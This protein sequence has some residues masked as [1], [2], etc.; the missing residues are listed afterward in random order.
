[1]KL[2]KKAREKMLKRGSKHIFSTGVEDSATELCK[3]NMKYGLAK[4]HYLQEQFGM[5]PDATFISTPD[6]TVTRNAAR[7]NQGIAYGGKLSWGDGKDKLVVLDTKPNT[8]GMLV[9]GLNSIPSPEKLLRK[10]QELNKE[11]TY[12]KN[13]KVKWDFNK[14]NHFI[15]VFKVE[16]ASIKLPHYMVIIHAGSPEMKSENEA[17]MGLYF[18]KSNYLQKVY[19]NIKTPFG[20][21]YILTE[22]DAEDYYKFYQF[23]EEFSKKRREIAFKELFGGKVVC[24][25]AHQGLINMNE[26]CLGCHYVK[27][28]KSLYPFS[29]RADLPSYLLK[30][31]RNFTDT[32]IESL[33]FHERAKELG[34]YDRLRKANLLPHGGGYTFTDSLAVDRVF[35]IHNKRYFEL[36]LKD[37]IGK[38]IISDPREIQFNYRGREVYLKTL[39]IG[40][41]KEAATLMPIYTVKV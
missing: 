33:G 41:G 39:E 28:F 17:G 1:M 40:L 11:D 19:K 37:G 12:I 26:I 38:K 16:M 25:H 22:K 30:A 29:I 7:W 21:M 6:E 8:C 10:I 24:N 23:A 32:Q 14:G 5:H 36:E 13:V 35:S 2:Q 9:G 4:M 27:D 18:N 15:D 20:P 34:V 31:K 3:A